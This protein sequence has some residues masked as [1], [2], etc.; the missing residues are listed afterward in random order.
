MGCWNTCHGIVRQGWVVGTRVRA[1]SSS[2]VQVGVQVLVR[3]RVRA[4]NKV[5]VRVRA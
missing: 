4:Y 2:S 3:G 5:R 1:L